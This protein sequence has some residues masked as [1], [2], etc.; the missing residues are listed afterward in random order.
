M[1]NIHCSSFLD[2]WNNCSVYVDTRKRD[3]KMWDLVSIYFNVVI[4]SDNFIFRQLGFRHQIIIIGS[5]N[6]I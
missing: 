4:I 3:V 1:R 5:L 2:P 6:I